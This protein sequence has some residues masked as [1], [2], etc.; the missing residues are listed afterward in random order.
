MQANLAAALLNNN[1]P[2][3]TL[4]FLPQS[5]SHGQMRHMPASKHI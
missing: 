5:K 2:E 4:A 1:N 3:I